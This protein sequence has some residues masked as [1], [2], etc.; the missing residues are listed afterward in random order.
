MSSKLTT[1]TFCIFY[2]SPNYD[3]ALPFYRDVLGWTVKNSYEHPG[4]RGTILQVREGVEFELIG[5]SAG[6][7]QTRPSPQGM[8]IR[9][10]MADDQACEAEFNR[11]RAA[12]V[13]ITK[14]VKRHPWGETSFGIRTPDGLMIYIYAQD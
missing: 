1:T 9:L 11:L 12:E 3:V 2:D 10:E 13:E 6:S 5:P 14:N 7:Q 4:R 8:R